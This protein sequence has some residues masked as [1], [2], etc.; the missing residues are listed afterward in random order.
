M[1][2][3]LLSV[4]AVVLV[5]ALAALWFIGRSR[6]IGP[7]SPDH[8]KNVKTGQ[9][10]S[11][12]YEDSS[13][14]YEHSHGCA[15]GSYSSSISWQKGWYLQGYSG[16]TVAAYQNDVPLPH[17]A[18]FGGWQRRDRQLWVDPADRVRGGVYRFLYIVHMNAPDRAERWPLAIFGC[19]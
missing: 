4:L 11:I 15:E 10:A 16:S 18:V 9:V 8:W 6:G 19:A 12:R 7:F 17:S 5:T 2:R 1:N 13:V 14:P 3:K